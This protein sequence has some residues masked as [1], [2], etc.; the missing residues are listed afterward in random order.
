MCKEKDI[1]KRRISIGKI[2][3]KTTISRHPRQNREIFLS[4]SHCFE[5]IMVFDWHFSYC[6]VYEALNGV[7]FEEEPT[8]IVNLPGSAFQA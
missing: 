8:Q 7:L 1:N 3:E 6:K 2:V 4:L 5:K